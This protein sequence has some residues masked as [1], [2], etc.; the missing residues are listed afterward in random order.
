MKKLIVIISI[1]ICVFTV[2]SCTKSDGSNSA[3]TTGIGGSLARFTIVDNYLY[4][5]D[6]NYINIYKISDAANPLFIKKVFVGN[7]IETIYPY[8]NMLFIGS[9]F[10]MFIY[11]LNNPENIEKVGEALH[12]RSCDPVVAKDT[13]AFVTLRNGTVCGSAINALYSYSV[14]NV[15]TP[16]LLNTLP[17]PTPIGLGYKDTTL[18]VCCADSGLAVINISNPKNPIIKKYIKTNSF[19]DVIPLNNTLICMV[20]TGLELYDIRDVNNVQFIKRIE[21]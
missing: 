3:N 18:F 19:Y 6:D 5:A 12:V 8:N 9:Q 10:G 21:N 16:V 14:K 15:S 1:T 11:S 13:F 20:K 7:S 2:I 4:L 17:L